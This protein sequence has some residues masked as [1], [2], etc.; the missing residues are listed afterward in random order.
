MQ[1]KVPQFIE[2]EDKLFG[3]FTLKQFA[4]M[5]GGAGLSVIIWRLMPESPFLLF[6]LAP[7]IGLT[8]ALTFLKPNGKP[9]IVLLQNAL[10]YVFNPK[11]LFWKNPGEEE[12]KENVA[13]GKREAAQV[14][15][16]AEK[17][18]QKMISG[19]QIENLA[20]KLDN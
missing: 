13:A 20:K 18:Q 6:I 15:R 12:S 3:P 10:S 16:K 14:E 8:L 2:V 5:M 9:F 7:V 19:E 17:Y 4:Y 1:H 11:K